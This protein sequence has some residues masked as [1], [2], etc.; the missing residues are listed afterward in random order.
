M[1]Y[2]VAHVFVVFYKK[3]SSEELVFNAVPFYFSSRCGA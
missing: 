1:N 2:Y 3:I